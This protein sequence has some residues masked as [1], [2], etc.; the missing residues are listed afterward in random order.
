MHKNIEMPEIDN[1]KLRE[2]IDALS[3]GCFVL[4]IKL[5]GENIE[6]LT[7][8]KFHKS[9]NMMISRENIVSLHI[10]YLSKEEREEVAALFEL[11]K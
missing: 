2:E 1:E 10:R 11:E 8:H 4:A 7:M 5:K 6:A 9:V 3:T